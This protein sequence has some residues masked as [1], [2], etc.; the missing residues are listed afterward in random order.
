MRL[1]TNGRGGNELKIDGLIRPTPL[2]SQP[3]P[4]A[5]PPPPPTTTPSQLRAQQR[6]V[7]VLPSRLSGTTNQ[8]R[9]SFLSL[10]RTAPSFVERELPLVEGTWD[11][12]FGSAWHFSIIHSIS[13][14]LSVAIERVRAE[15]R[16]P[17][18]A[19]CQQVP[20]IAPTTDIVRRRRRCRWAIF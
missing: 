4:S 6:G 3:E 15:S 5:V 12:G 7:V 9:A 18:C 10:W 13:R 20:R 17:L 14:V 11:R 1:Q 2:L 19:V 16:E 8:R